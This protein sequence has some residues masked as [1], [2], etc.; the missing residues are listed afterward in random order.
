M[1]SVDEVSKTAIIIGKTSSISVNEDEG[2]CIRVVDNARIPSDAYNMSTPIKLYKGE[3]ISVSC[4]TSSSISAIAIKEGFAYLNVVTGY[5]DGETSHLFEYTAQADCFV[6]VSHRNEFDCSISLQNDGNIIDRI[7]AD[8]TTQESIVTTITNELVTTS[9]VIGSSNDFRLTTPIKLFKGDK[10]VLQG[11][12]SSNALWI[13]KSDADGNVTAKGGVVGVTSDVPST[14]EY[15]AT[16]DEYVRV[17]YRIDSFRFLVIKGNNKD[18]IL[19]SVIAPSIG[20]YKED[21]PCI[22]LLDKKFIRASDNSLL[23]NDSF[24]ISKGIHLNK[25]DKI[26]VST[27]ASSSCAA[28]A[29][30]GI[31][32]EK[33]VT[34]IV[35]QGYDILAEYEYVADREKDVAICYN[36]EYTNT[37]IE[38]QRVNRVSML[39]SS[40]FDI[41]EYSVGSGKNFPSFVDAIDYINAV[42]Q[43]G[44]NYLLKVYEGVYSTIVASRIESGYKGLI[45]PNNVSIIGVGDRNNII[46]QGL[47]PSVSYAQYANTLSTINLTMNGYVENVTIKARNIRYCNH[48]DG[49]DSTIPGSMIK[50]KH[51]FKDVTFIYESLTESV[52][53]AKCCCGIGAQADKEIVFENCEFI[54]NADGAAIILHDNSGQTEQIRGARMHIDNCLFLANGNSNSCV[55]LSNSGGINDTYVYIRNSVLHNGVRIG[56]IASVYTNVI[57]LMVSACKNYKLVKTE[58]MESLDLSNDVNAF[59]NETI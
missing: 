50:V 37:S 27:K 46:L 48:D 31:E 6:V 29:E 40:E 24:A 16:N 13:A 58:N 43:S 22:L 9:G 56:S 44:K 41:V 49:D 4:N 28:I 36:N 15:T 38:I 51:T 42:Y 53:V 54:N 25:G 1:A 5:S 35:G 10:I 20:K 12:T 11:L 2:Y 45:I 47:L 18:T 57:K 32:G 3:K 8:Y 52:N 7:L 55:W 39:E 19:R 23:S 33:Y 21:A 59:C 30:V 34:L 14:Y 17:T 26:T